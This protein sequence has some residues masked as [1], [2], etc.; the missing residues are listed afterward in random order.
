LTPPQAPDALAHAIQRLLADDDQ[1]RRI[2]LAA[3]AYAKEHFGLARQV[4]A[5]LA[6]YEEIH[7]DWQ[8]RIGGTASERHRS[9]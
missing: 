8:Q 5:L 3:A 1:R 9:V 4:D 6:Y 7:L 2:G